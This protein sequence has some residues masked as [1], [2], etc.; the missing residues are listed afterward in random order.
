MSS[1]AHQVD[2][3]QCRQRPELSTAESV[4]E[5]HMEASFP[6][7]PDYGAIS[8]DLKPIASTGPLGV[9]SPVMIRRST[10]SPH[11]LHKKRIDCPLKF[12]R[13]TSFHSHWSSISVLNMFWSS[14]HSKIHLIILVTFSICHLTLPVFSS[15]LILHQHVIMWLQSTGKRFKLREQKPN[16]SKSG[17]LG[18]NKHQLHTLQETGEIHTSVRS[19]TMNSAP[20][21]NIQ[22]DER[23]VDKIGSDE[24]TCHII[25]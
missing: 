10:S 3:L 11:H 15:S 2:R 17:T 22:E 23:Q 13:L 19:Q 8:V 12:A 4:Q 25:S 5:G 1:V 14:L 18:Y 21:S 20:L 9:S 24:T 7:A 16:S 6:I